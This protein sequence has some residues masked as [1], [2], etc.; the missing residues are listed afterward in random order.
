M[1]VDDAE[2]AVRFPWYAWLQGSEIQQGDVLF[3]FQ[4]QAPVRH[5]EPEEDQAEAEIQEWDVVV[6]AQG[7]DIASEKVA[8]LVLSPCYEYQRFVEGARGDWNSA[9]RDDLRKGNIPGYHL[10]NSWEE[11]ENNVPLL[12]VDFH[13]LLSAPL[14]YVREFARSKETRPRLQPPYREH[15]AQAFARYFMRV[16]L[17]VDIPK[18]KLTVV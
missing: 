9:R 16:G 12:V 10:L 5:I 11:G 15:L 13:Q 3:G 2:S 7:C 8:S 14:D 6:L 1:F 4:L 17:P 18:S